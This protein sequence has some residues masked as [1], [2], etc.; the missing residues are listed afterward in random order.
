[1]ELALLK[2]DAVEADEN[3]TKGMAPAGD[4]IFEVFLMDKWKC[5][6]GHDRCFSTM[7]GPDCSEPE[8]VA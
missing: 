6:Q 1:M 4:V 7:P 8:N 2:T 5:V 3:P